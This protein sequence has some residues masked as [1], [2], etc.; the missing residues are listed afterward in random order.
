[1]FDQWTGD[2]SN[3]SDVNAAGATFTMGT[4]NAT[5]TATYKAVPATTYTLTVQNGTGSGSYAAGA[6]VP[7]T[8]NPP[9]DG[10]MF[11]QWTGDVSNVSDVNAAGA[12]ITMGTAN[13]TVTATYKDVPATTYTLTVQNGTGSGSYAA[14]AHVPITANPPADGKMFKNW[15]T[16]NGGTFANANAAS[17]TFTMPANAVTVTANYEDVPPLPVFDG[18]EEAYAAGSPAAPLKVKGAG[19]EQL[20]VFKVNGQAASAFAPHTAG[21]YTIEASS[22]DGKLKITRTVKVK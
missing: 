6:R 4:A 7:I 2:V 19:S 3:V 12:T 18:L 11:D 9:A 15:T 17:T 13:A 8:A 1:M 20:T 16:S 14:G 21:S 10:I 22:P 5:V